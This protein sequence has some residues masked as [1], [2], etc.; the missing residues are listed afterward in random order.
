VSSRNFFR[1]GLNIS[2]WA[3]F[4]IDGPGTNEGAENNNRTAKSD[5]V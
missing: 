5:H 3:K 2:R 1:E 4:E